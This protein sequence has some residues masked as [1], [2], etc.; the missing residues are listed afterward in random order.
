MYIVIIES[1]QS[2]SVCEGGTVEFTCVVMFPNGTS[3]GDAAWVTDSGSDAGQQP[4]HSISND[5]NGR[6]APA[7]VTTVLTVTNVR[8]SSNVTGYICGI[9]IGMNSVASDVGILTV[10]GKYLFSVW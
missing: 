9:G 3:P 2:Q 6:S 5:R 8:I 4:G 10:L 7:N 1:P